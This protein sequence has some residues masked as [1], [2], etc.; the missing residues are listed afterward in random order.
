MFALTLLPL[1]IWCAGQ[2]FLG[3]YLRDP[4]DAAT[5][6]QGGPLA[7]LLDY[8]RGILAMSPGHWLVLLGPYGLVWVFRALRRFGKT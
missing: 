4:G 1:A 5:A 6:R 8:V 7:L 2:L 3:D